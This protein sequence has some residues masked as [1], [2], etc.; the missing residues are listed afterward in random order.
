MY[1]ISILLLIKTWGD[2]AIYE[3]YVPLTEYTGDVPFKTMAEFVPGGKMDLLNF[4]IILV[5]IEI[6]ILFH[7]V[8]ETFV[9][10]VWRIICYC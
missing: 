7:A 1:I 3:N 4:L 10:A 6:V 2:L 8:L 5:L 9:R